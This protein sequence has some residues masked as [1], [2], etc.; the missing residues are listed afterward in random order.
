MKRRRT[1]RKKFFDNVPDMCVDISYADDSLLASKN[2]EA[3]TN[4]MHRLIR[5]TKG[6]GLEP[7]WAKTLHMPIRH[8]QDVRR[9]DGNRIATT[10]QTNNLG[11]VLT[12]DGSAK[13]A[14]IARVADAHGT[15]N[16]LHAVW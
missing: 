1:T 9:P 12:A 2:P 13:A 7:N 16:T 10:T 5:T 6:F 3:L 15:F 4:Y 14:V 8:N 11:S